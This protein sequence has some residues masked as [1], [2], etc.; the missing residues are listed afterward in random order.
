MN[1]KLIVCDIDNTLVTRHNDMSLK[2]KQ[3]IKF[4]NE[5]NIV[6]GIA[7]GR[8]YCQVEPLIKKWNIDVDFIISA[9][10]MRTCRF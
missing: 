8:P 2:T 3:A 1:P 9:K 6:F 4:L 5:K 7:S 10:W